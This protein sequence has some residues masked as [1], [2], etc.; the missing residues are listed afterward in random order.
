MIK[1]RT[2][3]IDLGKNNLFTKIGEGS[4][5]ITSFIAGLVGTVVILTLS[6]M[7]SRPGSNYR[8]MFLPGGILNSIPWAITLLFM[9]SAFILV[10]R[11]IRL[12]DQ[13]RRLSDSLATEVIKQVSEGEIDS[14]LEAIRKHSS[15]SL[16]L[17]RIRFILE[18]WNI[19][20]SIDRAENAARWQ[21]E[22]DDEV[23][24]SGYSMVKL[25]AWAMPILGFIGTVVGI[26]IAVGQFSS[27]LG[28][29]IGNIE[30]VKKQLMSVTSGLS[31][32]FLTT[33]HG[34]LG[35]LLIMLPASSLLNTE[36]NLILE[37]ERRCVID[38]LPH[39]YKRK[40]NV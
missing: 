18:Q 17:E 39:L 35:S 9:W 10:I 4:I 1:Q 32:A 19:S 26:S 40:D 8:A 3:D 12:K 34:L 33:L 29:E 31:F 38:L 37:I 2:G 6:N 16:Y 13:R 14:G 25:F 28:G 30:I 11:S 22:Y 23:I 36:H 7:L 15:S 20:S 24:N 5:I 21:A 27:F